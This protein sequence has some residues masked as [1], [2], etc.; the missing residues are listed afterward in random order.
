M[1]KK[2]IFTILWMVTFPLV[3]FILS[4]LMF[5]IL[6]R[7]GFQ[8]TRPPDSA[9]LLFGIWARLFW[10]SPA[11]ALVLSILCRLPGTK[12]KADMAEML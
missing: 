9:M 7:A 3:Y 11:V 5:A 8:N 12:R 6:G 10:L 4:M 2:V 1:K